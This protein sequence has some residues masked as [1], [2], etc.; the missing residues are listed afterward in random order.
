MR[1]GFH[2]PKELLS[3]LKGLQIPRKE[4]ITK[5]D[6][7]FEPKFFITE[8]EKDWV[9]RGGGNIQGSKFRIAKFFSEEHTAKE[10]ADYLKNEYGI[11]G[12]GVT[13]YNT[14]HDSKG[15]KF[16]RGSIS[17]PSAEVLM[18]WND[19][20][21]RVDRL[22]AED[23]YITQKDIDARIKDAKRTIENVYGDN[24]DVA[25]ERAKGVLA[26]YN[27]EPDEP[28]PVPEENSKDAAVFWN[29][30]GE[31]YIAVA[32]TD[33]GIDYTVYA[34]DL[35]PID[36]GVWEMESAVDLKFAAAQLADVPENELAEISDYNRFFELADEDY[37]FEVADELNKMVA[38]ALGNVESSVLEKQTEDV[39]EKSEL[40]VEP[41]SEKPAV[42]ALEKIT[43]VKK[44]PKSG[45]PFTYHF[46]EKDVVTGGAKT[47]Y[48]ANVEAIK[49]LQK[50]EAE[51]RYATP[52][53]QSI[54]AKYVG[55][56][57][58]PQA[59]TTDRAAEGIGNLGEATSTGWGERAE[60]IKGT[61]LAR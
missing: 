44:A 60:R 2:R 41:K 40:T 7:R 51:N 12:S 35:T 49:T 50:I 17:N 45:T 6:F 57:G 46:N 9:V 1:F 47:K 58:I 5:S 38:E 42:N 37:N 27:T 53:E 29:T 56:G 10:K 25:I 11:G 13:G 26:E 3:R 22:I 59:F 48:V 61:A 36:G 16:Q 23:R 31:N 33:E 19:V 14:W 55:W 21:E 28:A 4:F 20:A 43:A 18:K 52:E 15:L 54:L 34:P 32:Q 8:D 39:S 24:S 30:H